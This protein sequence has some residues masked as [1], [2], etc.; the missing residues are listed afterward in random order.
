MEEYQRFNEFIEN[1]IL[2]SNT[3]SEFA[4]VPLEDEDRGLK[5]VRF[6]LRYKKP[7][8]FV[9]YEYSD[10]EEE[11]ASRKKTKTLDKEYIASKP[12][13]RRTYYG[14]TKG[15]C[16]AHYLR[17]EACSKDYVC[18][19]VAKVFHEKTLSKDQKRRLK[20]RGQSD[21]FE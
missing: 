16:W 21:S 10:E 2:L 18:D 15:A 8:D 12:K 17:H 9:F 13:H 14:R 3:V 7:N 5:R 1:I 4:P 20:S 11:K 19:R 6:D